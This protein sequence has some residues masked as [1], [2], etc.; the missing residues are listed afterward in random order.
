M[1]F[2]FALPCPDTEELALL[3]AETT[4]RGKVDAIQAALP[5]K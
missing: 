3:Y 4:R 2:L 5:T 1:E